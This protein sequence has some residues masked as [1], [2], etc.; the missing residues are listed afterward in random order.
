MW[1]SA[2]WKN[3]YQFVRNLINRIILIED[4]LM[5]KLTIGARVK[6]K[7][8]P[9]KVMVLVPKKLFRHIPS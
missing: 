6:N 8:F 9:V 7:L 1:Q 5:Q 3:S 2:I 4:G